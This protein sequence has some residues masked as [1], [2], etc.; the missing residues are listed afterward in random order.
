MKVRAVQR[1]MGGDL[2]CA[3]VASEAEALQL[4]AATAGIEG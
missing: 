3:D 2:D 1:T 4:E